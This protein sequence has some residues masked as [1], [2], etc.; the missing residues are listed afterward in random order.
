MNY[1]VVTGVKKEFDQGVTDYLDKLHKKHLNSGLLKPQ[2][3]RTDFRL[4][5]G[6]DNFIWVADAAALKEFKMTITPN[7]IIFWGTAASRKD[8]VELAAIAGQ[9]VLL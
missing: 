5:V 1:L 8:Y 2:Y 4:K 9:R 6:K 7:Q 3:Y